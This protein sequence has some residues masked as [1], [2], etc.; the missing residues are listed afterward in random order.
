MSDNILRAYYGEYPRINKRTPVD[1]TSKVEADHFASLFEA[2]EDDCNIEPYGYKIGDYFESHNVHQVTQDTSTTASESINVKFRYWLAHPDLYYVGP[3]NPGTVTTI[4]HHLAI[5][6][7]LHTNVYWNTGSF[8]GYEASHL[9]TWLKGSNALGNI[10]KDLS[11][12]LTGSESNI[13]AAEA[14]LLGLYKVYCTYNGTAFNMN[15]STNLEYI[16]ALTEMNI[17]GGTV[18]SRKESDQKDFQQGEATQKL[19]LFKKYHTNRIFGPNNTWLRSLLDNGNACRLQGNG[20]FNPHALSYCH[21]AAGLILL[22]ADP[23]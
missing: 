10:K 12:I 15:T 8:T 17:C 11:Y 3:S 1:I 2:I 21:N 19:E 4:K 16:S 9:H 13:S 18:F 14:H 7:D 20:F 6:V 5:V 23:T 22:K